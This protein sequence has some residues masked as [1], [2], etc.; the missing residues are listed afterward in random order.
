MSFSG[1]ETK[2]PSS[3]PPSPK[4]HK[5]RIPRQA[6]RS[7]IVLFETLLHVDPPRLI[8]ADASILHDPLHL[9]LPFEVQTGPGITLHDIAAQVEVVGCETG[10]DIGHEGGGNAAVKGFGEVGWEEVE[11]PGAGGVEDC[12]QRGQYQRF[13]IRQMREE[14]AYV[15]QP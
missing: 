15:F 3:S 11:P 13:D 1:A 4:G 6:I 2:H 7:D 12:N 14:H 10:L 9:S 5:L 8:E